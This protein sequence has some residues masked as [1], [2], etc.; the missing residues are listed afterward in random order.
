MLKN[1]T[2]QEAEQYISLK[3]DY[4]NSGLEEATFLYL[5]P[6]C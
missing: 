6:F 2:P 1:I 5:N 3:E 4:T